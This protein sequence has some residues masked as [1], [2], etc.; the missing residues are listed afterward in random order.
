MS[1]SPYVRLGLKRVINAAGKMTALGG[2]AQG[3]EV[4]LAMADAAQHHV[5][6]GALRQLAARRI[7]E[8]TGAEDASITSGAA[9]GIAI[10]VAAMITGTDAAKA[11]R[12]PDSNGL[13][14]E[15]ILQ[16]GHDVHFGA[17]VS[18]MVS[19]GGGRPVLAG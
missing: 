18:Q 13:A 11:A 2:T 4:A 3:P 1:G 8:Q 12:L 19:L 16:A 7:A 6:M 9:A 14:N 17:R 10:G 15:I 5:E